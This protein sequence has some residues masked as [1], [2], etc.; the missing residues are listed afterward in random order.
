MAHL[1]HNSCEQDALSRSSHAR[2]DESPGARLS[3][4]NTSSMSS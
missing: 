1:V 4:G 3:A 2:S